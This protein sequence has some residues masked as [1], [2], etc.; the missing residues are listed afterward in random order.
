MKNLIQ[1]YTDFTAIKNQISDDLSNDDIAKYLTAP[2][3]HKMG[4]YFNGDGFDFHVGEA[5][6]NEI[7]Q[8]ERPAG[9]IKCPGIANI[10]SDHWTDGW[11]TQDDDGNYIDDTGVT[12][13]FVQCVEKCCE[14]G[15]IE[16]DRAEIIEEL[17]GDLIETLIA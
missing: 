6:G 8:D 10:D 13:T 16:D 7:A 12:L 3:G 9:I 15:D 11:T 5:I 14:D 2:F 4:A 1:I 17:M